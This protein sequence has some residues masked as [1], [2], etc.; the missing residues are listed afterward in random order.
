[1]VLEKEPPTVQGM[2]LEM[3]IEMVFEMVFQMVFGT[4]YLK[5]ASPSKELKARWTDS[6]KGF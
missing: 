2:V 4:A 1:M 6:R 3:V 5:M